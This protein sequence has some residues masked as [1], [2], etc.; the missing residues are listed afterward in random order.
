AAFAASRAGEVQAQV[1]AGVPLGAGPMGVWREGAGDL[2]GVP[3]KLRDY[4]LQAV[5]G[6][7]GLTVEELTSKLSDG[8]T[9]VDIAKG[10]GIAEDDVPALLKEARSD[11]LQ[12]AVSDGVLTQEQAE[13][14]EQ[15]PALLRMLGSAHM[16]RGQGFG[17][18][19]GMMGW[20]FFGRR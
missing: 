14:I 9:L 17:V 10:Q 2:S 16:R 20:G 18:P 5:A 19:G 12:L 13:W 7:L 8:Q 4:M 3:G 11:A 15:H 1:A 6:K